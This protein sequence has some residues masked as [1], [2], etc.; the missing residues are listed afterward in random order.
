MKKI[1]LLCVIVF[2]SLSAALAQEVSDATDSSAL[3]HTIRFPERYWKTVVPDRV[4]AVDSVN[5]KM[6]L[7]Q[8]FFGDS[9]RAKLEYFLAPSFRP[10][11]GCRV[12]RAPDGFLVFE[13]KQVSNYKEVEDA[14]E[15]NW[16]GHEQ[17]R[18]I[19]LERYTI[20][21]VSV[22]ISDSLAERLYA[23]TV[24]L[25]R[26]AEAVGPSGF[27]MLDGE[28][29]TFRC[30]V[31]DELWSLRFHQP[32]DDYE[33][34]SDLFQEMIADVQAGEFREATY[35]NRLTTDFIQGLDTETL[36]VDAQVQYRKTVGPASDSLPDETS[37]EKIL[38]GDLPG[39]DEQ[40]RYFADQ[41][42]TPALGCRIFRAP[43]ADSSTL[44]VKWIHDYR[45]A[46][47]QIPDSIA[48]A[49]E[50]RKMAYLQEMID[51]ITDELQGRRYTI[52]A[53]SV[54]I[55]DDL[56]ERLYTRTVELLR[57]TEAVG[58]SPHPILDGETATF[59]CTVGNTLWS[60][61][62]LEPDSEYKQLSDLFRAIIAD[63]QADSFDE[64][65]YLNLLGN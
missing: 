61:S 52:D 46:S 50:E 49:G 10:A 16:P 36:T 26:Y 62:Y 13:A 22:P 38:F 8:R 63:V 28:T 18:K 55:S 7:E 42:S 56:A 14:I 11:V 1:T 41:L 12:F 4:S 35:F 40:V 29:A 60:L 20:N 53:E 39:S 37:R 51:R 58:R 31:G 6:G 54:S 44:E 47:L 15:Q 45:N 5:G 23:Q 33:R 43:N 57:R 30:V 3:Q 19:R 65:K 17:R 34:L 59:R 32:T 64:A 27:S 48:A 24:G 25:V 9:L 2:S 21:E